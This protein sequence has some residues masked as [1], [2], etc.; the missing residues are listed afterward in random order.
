[1]FPLE[2]NFKLIALVLVRSRK[3]Y[4]YVNS[5]PHNRTKINFV[6]GKLLNKYLLEVFLF[7]VNNLKCK[8]VQTTGIG[9]QGK[10][11]LYQKISLVDNSYTILQKTNIKSREKSK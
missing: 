11:F 7:V 2:R 5:S 9:F 4:F 10:T 3:V 1:L 8:N 6:Q